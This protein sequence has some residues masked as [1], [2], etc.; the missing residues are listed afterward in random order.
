MSGTTTDEVSMTGES[1]APGETLCKLLLHPAGTNA[2]RA[3]VVIMMLAFWEFGSGRFLP[4]V[5]LSSPSVIGVKLWSWIADGSLGMHLVATLSAAG[6][7]YA[8]GALSGVASGLV[9]GLLPRV[10]RVASPFVVA[11]YALPKVALA[12]FFVIFL[13]IGLESKVA[14]VA[15]TVYFLLLYNTLDGVRDLDRDLTDAFRLM[16]ATRSE[17]ARHVLL[18]GIQPW[19]YS[20]LR[21]AVRYAFTAAVLGELIASNQGIGYLI[22]SSAGHY[23]SS[24]VFA[25]V[26]VLVV[27]SVISTEL[28]TRAERAAL[29][30]QR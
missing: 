9:L 28:I 29:R 24:G 21:I 11:L 22:E 18:P 23:N 17:V 26:F 4:H 12:P 30:W 16:G 3:L 10:E 2:A 13:G 27:C 15:V 5:W 1:A 7:G 20:G 6:F 14:L 25:G 8:L 19:I